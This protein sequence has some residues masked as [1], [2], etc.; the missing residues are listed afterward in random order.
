[1]CISRIIVKGVGAMSFVDE[2]K[3]S[4]TFYVIPMSEYSI[5]EEVCASI[6]DIRRS[7]ERKYGLR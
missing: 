1:M 6:D 3:V 4:R 7:I 5:E 2:S